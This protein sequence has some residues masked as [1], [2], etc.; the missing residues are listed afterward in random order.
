MGIV[1]QATDVQSQ[2]MSWAAERPAWDELNGRQLAEGG[3]SHEPVCFSILTEHWADEHPDPGLPL[4][5]AYPPERALP[6]Q[7][8]HA[9]DD[10]WGLGLALPR[11]PSL[12]DSMWLQTQTSKFN[13]HYE[14]LQCTLVLGSTV[15]D[16][17][18]LSKCLGF[19]GGRTRKT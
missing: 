3:L 5:L 19:K 11:A 9:G 2:E 7:V 12:I 14:P 6:S 13:K 8:T 15:I 18:L 17:S 4:S 1:E 16:W 10:S